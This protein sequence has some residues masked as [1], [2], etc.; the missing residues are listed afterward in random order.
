MNE[1]NESGC[2]CIQT[3]LGF[4]ALA[5]PGKDSALFAILFATLTAFSE[6]PV[7]YLIS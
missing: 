4:A 6:Q 2:M 5:A 7:F 3:H 1:F